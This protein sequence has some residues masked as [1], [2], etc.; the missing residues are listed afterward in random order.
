[1]ENTMLGIK[2]A[3]ASPFF[4]MF[5][6]MFSFWLGKRIGQRVNSPLA[7]PFLI[8]I[9]LV[10]AFLQITG[11]SLADY[12]RGADVMSLML[13]PATAILGVSIYHRRKLL[14]AN[15]LPILAGCFTGA[16]VSI[17]STYSLCKWFGI[18][19]TFTTSLMPKSV[20]T[21][22]AMELSQ[23]LGGLVSLTVAAVVITGIAGAALAPWLIKIMKVK[24]PIAIGVA[25]GAASHV[26]G[27]AK[28]IE[29]GETEG[30]TSGIAIGITGLITV[31]LFLLFL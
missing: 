4:G 27:T 29:L 11:I 15:A 8:A 26:V 1:M 10:I 3:I 17:V 14:C 31:G 2:S 25:F 18:H 12:Q 20:T 30:A 23:N 7:N 28:A 21:P 5:L 24:N 19:E 22:I 9:V 13:I 6:T 16:V